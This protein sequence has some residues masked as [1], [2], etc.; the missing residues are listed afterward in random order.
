MSRRGDF[1]LW[2]ETFE[3]SLH[4]VPGLRSG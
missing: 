1:H 3:L 4:L 2:I